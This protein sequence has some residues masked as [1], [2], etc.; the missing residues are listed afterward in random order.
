MIA[1]AG[2][3][4]VHEHSYVSGPNA[5]RFVIPAG[6]TTGAY[7]KLVHSHEGG[8]EP[9]QHPNT[10]PATYTIDKDAWFR[11][12]GLRG[13]GRKKFTSKPTGEQLPIVELEEWQRSFEV[14]VDEESCKQAIAA[15]GGNVTGGGEV[16]AHRMVH[17]FKLKPIVRRAR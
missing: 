2:R 15:M 7:V 17:A 8:D 6:K 9:H 10:G 5:G 12:T 14:I 1:K 16:T 13:G 3:F 11:S 4:E